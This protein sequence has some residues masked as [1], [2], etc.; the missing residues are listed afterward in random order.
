MKLIYNKKEVN[1][2]D[3]YLQKLNIN[4][5]LKKEINSFVK[6]RTNRIIHY[7]MGDQTHS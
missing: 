2:M 7:I 3:N 1:K 4:E 6:Q 5:K